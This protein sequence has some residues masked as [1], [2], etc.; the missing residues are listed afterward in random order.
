MA[1][2]DD[3]V[4]VPAGEPK[5]WVP[6]TTVTN[7]TDRAPTRI[8]VSPPAP[9]IG[10]LEAAKLGYLSGAS[11]NFADEVYGL[12]KASGLPDWLGGFRAPVGA[13]RMLYGQATTPDP[14]FMQNYEK[15]VAERRE[16]LKAAEAQHP[17]IFLGGNVMGALVTPGA[18]V[19]R[20]A[21]LPARIGRGA[22]IGA[23]YGG[24]SGLG[25][26]ENDI[27]RL[28]Q[29]AMG[30]VIGGL[31][32]GAAPPVIEG[33]LATGRVLTAPI[34]GAVR[35]ALN[36]EREAQRY[37][38]NVLGTD[39]RIDPNATARLTPGEFSANVA[40]G[41]PAMLMDLG[42]EATRGLAR[43]AANASPEAEQVFNAVI[44]PRFENQASR[45]SNFINQRFNF[46]NATSRQAALEDTARTANAAA[47]REA[48]TAG[49]GNVGSPELERLASSDAVAR[50]MR[51]AA[52]K[53]NDEAIVGGYGAMNP[54]VTFTP[55]GRV[56]FQKSPGG[57]PTYP[58]LQFWDLTRRELNSAKR[59]AERAGNDTE[60]RRLGYFAN[61]INSE[62]DRLVP[63]YATARHGAAGFFGAENA[64][65][66]GGNLFGQA[67]RLG[68]D[69]IRQELAR[70]S[71]QEQQLFRDAYAS[72][73]IS[74]IEAPRA[75]Q[76]VLTAVP[77]LGQSPALEAE[78]NLG[79]GQ[80]GAN[81]LRGM[82]RVESI[83]DRARQAV[84][85]QSTTAKQLQRLKEL[86]VYGVGAGIGAGVGGFDLDPATAIG[87]AVG[88]ALTV[89]RGH[90]NQ[91]VMRH[92]AEILTSQDTTAAG[93]LLTANQARNQ[94]S[95]RR[96][97]LV[98]SMLERSALGSAV[99]ATY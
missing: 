92:V 13:A 68:V 58:D 76:N 46:P 37:V 28:K 44:D 69:P 66:A 23:V 99:G 84:Q 30:T 57:V 52:S 8:T 87:G 63:Q 96:S 18:T 34:A 3:W 45:F 19:A 27:D 80:S 77:H 41:G 5:D 14:E 48:Y 42:G 49:A 93:K 75:R 90:I 20:A 81:E 43:S 74:S 25:V 47:Y 31:A 72:R 33:A 35:G 7:P 10:G 89:G 39:L 62:L 82:R 29:G 67:R 94:A 91:N 56:I 21:T 15:A 53:A 86:G 54:R 83:M 85:G 61:Q 6:Y 26:G 36:P 4:T 71:P 97:A 24:A 59:V 32:G 79:L 78:L 50:A 22:A 55:D 38:S 73:L 1:E 2:P 98:R 51:T 65:E 40:H 88:A 17:G 70:M 11:A 9:E 64:L 12:S 16:R 95:Q 60:A